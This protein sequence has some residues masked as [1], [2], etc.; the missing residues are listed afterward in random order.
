M[1]F[2]NLV[3][4]LQVYS[5]FILPGILII[6]FGCGVSNLFRV[7]NARFRKVVRK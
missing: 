4:C 1:N 2:Q 3:T 6:L 5:Y 7:N